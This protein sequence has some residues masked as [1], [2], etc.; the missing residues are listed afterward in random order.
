MR[1]DFK[2]FAAMVQKPVVMIADR[3]ESIPSNLILLFEVFLITY[4]CKVLL[5]DEALA[6]LV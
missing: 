6:L 4:S 5:A 2:A 3:P 1:I